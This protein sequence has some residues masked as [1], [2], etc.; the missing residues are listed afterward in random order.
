MKMTKYSRIALAAVV[1]IGLAQSMALAKNADDED[2]SVYNWGPW[3]KMI[4]PAAGPAPV[5]VA[6]LPQGFNYQPPVNPNPPTPEPPVDNEPVYRGYATDFYWAE[7]YQ[8]NDSSDSYGYSYTAGLEPAQFELDAEFNPELGTGEGGTVVASFGVNPYNTDPNFP[9][10]AS[11]EMTGNYYD[12]DFEDYGASFWADGYGDPDG[13]GPIV[14]QDSEIWDATIAPPWLGDFSG[15]EWYN[16]T[17]IAL[18]VDTPE[19]YYG[20][21]GIWVY[22]LETPLDVITNLIAGNITAVYDGYSQSYSCCGEGSNLTPVRITVNFGDGTWTGVWNNGAD[23]SVETSTLANGQLYVFGDVGYRAG[24]VI[25]GAN[26][27]SDA[28]QF[29]ADDGTID[30]ERSVI[31]GNF[32]TSNGNVLAGVTDIIKTTVDSETALVSYENARS[33]ELFQTGTGD[34]A[35]MFTVQE[36]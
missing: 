17:A 22:G 3:D 32:F 15:G 8:D 23:G 21:D 4:T 12:G 34:A 35:E 13:D 2:K 20:G 10:V 11:I 33:V 28:A 27:V 9:P 7:H 6:Q 29:S 31:R 36:R 18:S 1:S 26:I 5:F 30:Q 25:N 19:G 16:R 24:G 14:S